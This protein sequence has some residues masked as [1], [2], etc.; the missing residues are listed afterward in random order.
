MGDPRKY[1]PREDGARVARGVRVVEAVEAAEVVTAAVRVAVV[2]AVA[3]HYINA[4]RA[5]TVQIAECPHARGNLPAKVVR[6]IDPLPLSCTRRLVILHQH[7]C[8]DI[9]SDDPA[10]LG[11][12]A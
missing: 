3:G 5:V 8:S 9:N 2:V 4:R 11:R 10:I 6:A 12:I 1:Q 7:F